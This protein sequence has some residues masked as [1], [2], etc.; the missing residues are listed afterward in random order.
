MA[1]RLGAASAVTTSHNLSQLLADI[2]QQPTVQPLKTRSTKTGTPTS[3]VP[4]P[5]A[6]GASVREHVC[7]A[8]FSGQWVVD[9][10]NVVV[11]Q[12][13]QQEAE[14]NASGSP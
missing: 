12:A 11:G 7:V 13:V 1:H 5:A 9:L 3:A 10:I 2:H 8:T 6:G 4:M 14:R